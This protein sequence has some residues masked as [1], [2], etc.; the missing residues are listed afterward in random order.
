MDE[1][2]SLD[3]GKFVDLMTWMLTVSENI[4]LFFLLFFGR[5]L[6]P[7]RWHIKTY[8][9][10]IHSICLVKICNKNWWLRIKNYSYGFRDKPMLFLIA[11]ALQSDIF[12]SNFS[13]YKFQ[14]FHVMQF[15]WS[16]PSF[17][18]LVILFSI[19][20]ILCALY[21][22]TCMCMYIYE[23]MICP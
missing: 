19:L 7:R 12:I 11:Y 6:Q 17:M 9:P 20:C 1:Q 16:W 8:M 15:P 3:F 4:Y 23:C 10:T 22:Y 21:L 2:V 18:N 5:K 13:K 14:S